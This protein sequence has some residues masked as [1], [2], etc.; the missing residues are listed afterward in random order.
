MVFGFSL[1][2][3]L[4][5]GSTAGTRRFRFRPEKVSGILHRDDGPQSSTFSSAMENATNYNSWIV[6]IFAPYIGGAVMEL[7]VGHGGFHDLVAPLTS[8]YVGIDIDPLLID[9]ARRRNP[10]IEY[11]V[12]DVLSDEF[13][14]RAEQLR[15]DTILCFNVLEHLDDDRTAIGR[16]LEALPPGGHL[17]LYVPAFQSLYS[18]MDR[19]AGHYRRYTRAS[20]RKL[21]PDEGAAIVMMDYINPIGGLGWWLNKRIKHASLE[22]SAVLGQIVLFD[23]YV[24]P[25]SRLLTPMFKTVFGQSI[26]CVIRRR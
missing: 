12:A 3:A 9:M 5:L 16:L 15:I 6:D 22:S 20:L 7:G 17:L 21:V 25:V 26:A 18:E 11:I 4:A 24:L 14:L 8:R 23:K 10:G 19:L 2:P 13:R 1:S